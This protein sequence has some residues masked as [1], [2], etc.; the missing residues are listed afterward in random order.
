M[1]GKESAEDSE[2]E[3]F[4]GTHIVK[5]EQDMRE[6]MSKV[7]ENAKTS[8]RDEAIDAADKAIDIVA[9]RTAQEV[10]TKTVTA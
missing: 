2:R 6:E 1:I 8:S 3:V 9:A 4:E 10:A 7:K 5:F